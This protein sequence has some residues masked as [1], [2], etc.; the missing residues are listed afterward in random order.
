MNYHFEKT[1]AC[2]IAAQLEAVRK[3]SPL[4]H[5]ITNY[6]VMS[7]TADALL[8]IGAS[9]I[10]TDASEEVEE[11]T[12]ASSALVLNMGTISGRWAEAIMA[13]AR[14]AS[15][16]GIPTV[17]DPVGAGFTSF[18]DNFIARLLAEQAPTLIKGNAS[19]I[20][21]VASTAAGET[22]TVKSRGVDT[23]TEGEAAVSSAVR[24]AE[25]TGSVVVITGPTDYI[26]DGVRIARIRNG[27]EIM[28]RT[29]GM[30]CTAAA[31]SGA[32]LAVADDPFIG[33]VSAMAV[34]GI[35]GENAARH[36][37]GNGSFRV[38]FLDELY[39]MD[40]IE[41]TEYFIWED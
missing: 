41:I 16:A 40:I 2:T 22:G 20:Q 19:E 4:I 11:V 7:L 6:V 18:R 34:M 28:T 24:L 23:S 9:P 15:R 12:A 5:N 31:L 3:N 32:F 29:A 10:M 21:A 35:A 36:S 25:A 39:R 26:T 1:D 27:A 13:S 33:A 14:T 38:N 8:A 17:L 37:S 30:G